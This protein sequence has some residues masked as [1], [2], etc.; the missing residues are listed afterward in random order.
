M[1]MSSEEMAAW[2][3]K[4]EGH[5]TWHTTDESDQKSRW[6]RMFPYAGQRAIRASWLMLDSSASFRMSVAGLDVGVVDLQHGLR[7]APQ[8]SDFAAIIDSKA[9]P[10]ARVAQNEPHLISHALDAGVLGLICPMVVS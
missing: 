4:Y 6:S 8:T 9:V 3:T 10:F 7:S 2:R 1:S 5:K